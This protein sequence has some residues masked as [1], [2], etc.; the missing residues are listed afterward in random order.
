DV[1]VKPCVRLRSPLSF[2]LRPALRL[3]RTR[4][5]ILAA[6]AVVEAAA[7]PQV[8]TWAAAVW[9][10]AVAFPLPVVAAA[11]L[12]AVAEPAL[13]RLTFPR[14]LRIF[15]HPRRPARV[16]RLLASRRRLSPRRTILRHATLLPRT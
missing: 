8:P 2:L 12:T 16:L 1:E 5:T 9:A 15:R 11:F 10:A 4:S 14:Q 13:P 6:A 7:L 3:A